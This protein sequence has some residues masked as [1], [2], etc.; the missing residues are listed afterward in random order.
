MSL[1]PADPTLPREQWLARIAWL[2]Y[3]QHLTQAQIG[4]RLGLSRVTVNRLL[5]EARA[6]GIIEVRIRAGLDDPSPTAAGNSGDARDQLCQVTRQ[7]FARGLITATGGNLSARVAGKPDEVWIT[8]AAVFKGDLRPGMMARIDLDGSLLGGEYGASSEWQV[9]C[10]IYRRRPDAQAV[11]HTHA[12]YA[13]LMALTGTPFQPISSEAAFCGE[14]PVVPFILPGTKELG[15]AVAG[16]LGSQGAAVL[17][18]N[19]GLVVAGS[20]LRRAADLTE[21][22]EVTAHKLITCRLMGVQPA[23]LPEDLVKTLREKGSLLA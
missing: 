15:E 4:A 1:P 18:Q 23:A 16:A 22:I 3:Q 5:K 7:L 9:H 12:P 13:T 20:S 6:S 19:H 2:Y 17:M 10:T 8:P 11:V 14:I 21:T